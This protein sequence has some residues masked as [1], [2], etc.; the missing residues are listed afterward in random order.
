LAQEM[1]DEQQK[2]ISG[3]R[4]NNA[5]GRRIIVMKRGHR[6]SVRD[7]GD[8]GERFSMDTV[9]ASYF[10]DGLILFFWG[11][12]NFILRSLVHTLRKENGRMLYSSY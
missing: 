1:A 7:S 2:M 10:Y 9:W 4:I 8:F 11:D 6:K 3:G 5:V 12:R